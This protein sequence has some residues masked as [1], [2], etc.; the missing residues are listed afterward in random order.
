MPYDPCRMS[1]RLSHCF[2][3]LNSYPMCLIHDAIIALRNCCLR[4]KRKRCLILINSASI[5]PAKKFSSA[6]R[7]FNSQATTPVHYLQNTT[8]PQQNNNT[9]FLSYYPTVTMPKIQFQD[10]IYD[11]R[12]PRS[13]RR[14]SHDWEREV[15]R[16]NLMGSFSSWLRQHTAPKRSKRR[17]SAARRDLAHFCH[18]F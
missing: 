15:R 5:S 1:P 16:Q 13:A 12:A 6:K 2:R 17:S 10:P 3:G 4:D 11:L 14:K 8:K 18:E 7:P 9:A